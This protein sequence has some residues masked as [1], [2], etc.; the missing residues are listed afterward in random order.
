MFINDF[1]FKS[2]ATPKP[3]YHMQVSTTTPPIFILNETH[4]E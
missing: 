4:N 3:F 1:P 2:W